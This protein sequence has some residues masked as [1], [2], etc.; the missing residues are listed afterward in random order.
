VEN[1]D[2]RENMNKTKVIISVECQKLI[3]KAA[4]WSCDVC[5]RGVANNSI[6][7]TSCKKWVHKKFSGT[8]ANMSKVTKSFICRRC[9]N[10]VTSIGRTS[11]DICASANQKLVDKFCYLGDMLS[12]DG[13][14]DAAVEAESELDGINAGSWYHCLPIRTRSPA[15]ARM[16]DCTASVVKLTLIVTLTLTSHIWQNRHFPLNGRIMRQNEAYRAISCTLKTTS[17]FILRHVCRE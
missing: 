12:V 13:D 11:V 7:C 2:I 14:A 8:K 1:R 4:R 3:Q 5:G 17:G 15:V 10:P 6:Q 16:A 9:S